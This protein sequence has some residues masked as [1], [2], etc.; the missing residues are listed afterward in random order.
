[1]Q[2]F[3]S[4]PCTKTLTTNL[5]LQHSLKIYRQQTFSKLIS[6]D[7][8]NSTI[9]HTDILTSTQWNPQQ[10]IITIHHGMQK[11]IRQITPSCIYIDIM[12]VCKFFEQSLSQ[13]TITPRQKCLQI[14]RLSIQHSLKI[15]L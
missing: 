3:F 10:F 15:Y 4:Q 14:H 13:L 7:I 9:V 11:P 1:M 6:Q 8:F 12:F 5:H 2:T